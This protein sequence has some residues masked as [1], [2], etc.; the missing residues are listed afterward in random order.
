MLSTI[1][2]LRAGVEEA[3]EP[4]RDVPYVIVG[5]WN[6]VGSDRQTGEILEAQGLGKPTIAPLRHLG[7]IDSFTYYNEGGGFPP[8]LLDLAIYDDELLDLEAGWIL[9]SSTLSEQ[10]RRGLGLRED[11]SRSS[12]HLMLVVDVVAGGGPE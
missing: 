7:G 9:E 10:E 2:E 1:R 5:D 8:G 11:D 6:R 3:L 12:D 4:F